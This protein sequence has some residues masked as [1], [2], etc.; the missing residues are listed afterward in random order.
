MVLRDSIDIISRPSELSNPALRILRNGKA[1][2][3]PYRTRDV[4][5]PLPVPFAFPISA[6]LLAARILNLRLTFSIFGVAVLGGITVSE[7]EKRDEWLPASSAKGE[8][9]RLSHIP[10]YICI[11]LCAL[12][13]LGDLG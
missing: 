8:V 4:L 11:L 1:A 9:P 3:E 2:G 12:D 7:F 5:Q 6:F 13:D 10:K